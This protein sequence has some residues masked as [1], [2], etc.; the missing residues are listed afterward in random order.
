MRLG[1]FVLVLLWGGVTLTN[2]QELIWTCPVHRE[3]T[4]TAAGECP[5][6]QRVL[7]RSRIAE[8]W[9]C[10]VHALVVEPGP[11][12]CPLCERALY[13]VSREVAYA[14]PMHPEVREVEEGACPICGMALVLET[15]TRP[16]QDHNPKHGGIFFMAPDSWH[17]IEGTY[18]EPGVF[19]VYFYDNFSEPM[20]AKGFKGRA[21]LE[22]SFDPSTRATKE[23]LTYPLLPSREGEYLEARVGSDSLP[24]E[25]TAKLQFERDADFERF[26]FVFAGL[27]NDVDASSS[28]AATGELV[29]PDT[30][31]GIV[32]AIQARHQ[33]VRDLISQGAYNQIY[34]SALEA[35]DLALAL[36]RHVESAELAWAL[37]E[38]VRAA[39]L[40]DDYGD[41]GN[42]EKVG[43]AYERF[44]EAVHE[45]EAVYGV[46]R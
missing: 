25:I 36:E 31:G 26:D 3:V 8:A 41:L 2:A 4:E 15:S 24:R 40:L 46:S 22:E 5:I 7:V 44:E 27:S 39:W 32:A 23:L 11:G 19:R 34:V 16:H 20:S 43:S 13:P 37:R 6:C 45:I 10:P 18:P 17:H 35:K 14:C 21:V 42:R 30:P 33:I 28:P 12:K 38:L 1:I 29:V 9:S